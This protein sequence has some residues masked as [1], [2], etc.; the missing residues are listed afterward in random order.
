MNLTLTPIR[1]KQRAETYFPNKVGIVDGD[2]R[3]TYREFGQRANRLSN[4]LID[5]GI[6]RGER[7]AWLGYNSHELLEA[8]YGVVQ[9][10]A[11]LLPLN[12][13]LTPNEIAFILNDSDS[14]AMF[15]NRDLQPIVDGVRNQAPEVKQYVPL[16]SNG[17][18]NDYETLIT[19]AGADFTPP[20]D[21]KD[22]DL[23]ELFYTS[24]TTANPKGVM[25]THRNL[26]LHA[27][28]IIAGLGVDDT[29]VQLHTIP[30]F[31]VNG[32]GTP[33]TLACMGAR[34]VIVKKFDPTEVLEL[35]QKERVTNFAMVPTMAN[36]IIHHPSL[37]EY[38]L[39]SLDYIA[40]GGAASPVDLIRL[41][42]QKLG[43]RAYG[44]YGLT[45][46]VPVLTQSFIKDH[47]KNEPDEARWRRQ[48]MAGFPMP[49]VEIDI[50]DPDDKP[51]AH[52][53]TSVGEVV[54]RADNVMAG[55]WKLPEETANVM[56]S[57]WFHTG[58]M[59]T[60]DEHGYFLIV[61]RKKD[62][63]I[64]GG[65][66]IASIE[67]EKAVYSHPAVFE[68]A[69]VAVPDDRWGEVPKALVVV[70]PGESLSEQEII[71]HCRTNLPG[72]KVPKSVEFFDVLPKG[73]TGK[74]LKKELREKYWA[75]YA[76]R[77]H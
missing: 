39:S 36:A 64:S 72:F 28:Q 59:A 75:G 46:T 42:E 77:V 3:M 8:Y 71:D 16:E 24:G 11:V 22:D 34:H 35:I 65:E 6:K 54:V 68:C 12:I 49:G 69:V 53:N 31:H 60:V 62:I 13:R 55:Y 56:R 58:D 67:V 15:Y 61:D 44:G 41:V 7:V 19:A 38:D 52:D 37:G 9:M 25:M 26:Y 5:M 48:A 21:I 32:W 30:L 10:G 14:V 27:L 45:E 51:V 74:I 57:G 70:K 43:C 18:G 33:H 1:F 23:A 4:A 66:N 40:I 2:I 47:L 17:D 29:V 50:F 73:G 76:K 63:I 20:S